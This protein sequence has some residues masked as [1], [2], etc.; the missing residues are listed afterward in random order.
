MK[1]FASALFIQTTMYMC[2]LA[3]LCTLQIVHYGD[4]HEMLLFP[5]AYA[6]PN[7]NLHSNMDA[8]LY[9]LLFALPWVCLIYIYLL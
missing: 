7:Y 6:F 4:S 2:T 8:F 3:S 9:F 5:L 1:Y